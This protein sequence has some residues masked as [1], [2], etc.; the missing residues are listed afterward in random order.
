[1]FSDICLSTGWGGGV[2]PVLFLSRGREGSGR[3]HSILIMPGRRGGLGRYPH[4]V[5]YAFP[6]RSRSSPRG[7]G[8]GG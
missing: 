3:I 4:Q 7:E 6:S 1:M 8:K 2:H 5:T